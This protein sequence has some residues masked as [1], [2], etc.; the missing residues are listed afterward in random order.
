M[1]FAHGRSCVRGFTAALCLGLLAPA[2][3]AAVTVEDAGLQRVA[4]KEYAAK[5]KVSQAVARSRLAL[6]DRAVGLG[7]EL[8]RKLGRAYGG[9]WFDAA[10]RGRIKVGVTA[11]G[12]VAKVERALA[13]RGL[14]KQG[15]VVRVRSSMSGLLRAH[16]RLDPQV[17]DLIDAGKVRTGVEPQNNAVVVKLASSV[18][19]Q[20]RQRVEAVAAAAPANV[21]LRA[22]GRRT[23]MAR[24]T[25]CTLPYCTTPLRGGVRIETSRYGCTAGFIARSRT[26]N[27][28]YVLTA[29]HC[30]AADAG[31]WSSRFPIGVRH[32]WEF[33][34][35]G[36]N[37]K[38][39]D[40]GLLRVDPTSVWG[41][42]GGVGPYVVVDTSAS[43]TYEELYRISSQVA[44]AVG[45]V[46]CM[47][48]SYLLT[49]GHYTACG[50]VVAVDQTANYGG[51]HIVNHLNEVNICGP[52]PGTSGGPYYKTHNAYGVQSGQTVGAPCDNFQQGVIR[53]GNDLNVNVQT[54]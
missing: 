8:E 52:V 50:T 9:M 12:S 33:G 41:A 54:G 31:T 37:G 35:V 5:F 17:I 20:E 16:R 36:G 25:A 38:D 34:G 3:A 48:G 11:G 47:T 39:G 51:G 29:G 22:T 10:D 44:N 18:S 4:A 43:T 27:K 45:Q 53:A 42:P 7:S 15:D 23:L 13:D 21:V 24:P 1:R 32:S 49:N 2:A 46:Q 6:Q 19:A 14:A 28:P 30:M 26:D 40:A